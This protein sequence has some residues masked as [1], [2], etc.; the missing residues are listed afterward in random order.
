MRVGT[1]MSV[2]C[3]RD[4]NSSNS[5]S[6]NGSRWAMRVAVYAF[7]SSTNRCSCGDSLSRIHSYGSTNTSLWNVRVVGVRRARGGCGACCSLVMRR[8]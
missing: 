3:T 1:D 7:S 5:R 2:S 8:L 4:L 6:R